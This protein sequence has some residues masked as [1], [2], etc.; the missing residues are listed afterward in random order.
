M[1]LEV[2]GAGPGRTGTASLK[3]ALEMLGLGRCYHMGE[4]M[5]DPSASD[6]WAAAA[7]GAPDWDLIFDGYAAAVDYPAAKFWREL[8]DY[9]PQSK[10]L[11]SV[12]DANGWFDSVHETIF[13]PR[14]REWIG[15]T[16]FAEFMHLTVHGPFGDRIDDRAFMVDYFEKHVA[17]VKA[18]IPPER[19]LVYEVKQGWGPLCEFLGLP[20]PAEPFPRVNSRAETG[21]MIDAMIAAGADADVR[22]E[23]R[24]RS[25]DLFKPGQ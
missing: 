8:A 24:E 10:V 13:S 5:R 12:R 23:L 6:R 7:K 9:Y 19:L 22:A 2:V 16:P 20:E 21:A 25:N 11:L 18:A 4:V 14:I 1:T 17:A 15:N 3:V